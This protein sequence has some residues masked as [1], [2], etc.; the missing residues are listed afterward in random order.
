M[1]P[2]FDKDRKVDMQKMFYEDKKLRFIRVINQVVQIKQKRH[3]MAVTLFLLG[4]HIAGDKRV[5]EE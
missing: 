1:E 2:F 5:L 4:S 3:I